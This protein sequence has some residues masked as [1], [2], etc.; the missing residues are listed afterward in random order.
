MQLWP[1]RPG[2]DAISVQFIFLVHTYLFL[3]LSRVGGGSVDAN[4][5]PFH[6]V[7]KELI[8]SRKYYK[9]KSAG[10]RLSSRPSRWTSEL[11]TWPDDDHRDDASEAHGHG[12][13]ET[14]ATLATDEPWSTVARVRSA[15]EVGHISACEAPLRCV[16]AYPGVRRRS[17]RLTAARGRCLRGWSGRCPAGPAAVQHH[18]PALHCARREPMPRRCC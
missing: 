14:R 3:P 6:S 18:H 7:D 8:P 13:A 17:H 4:R 16:V 11:D 12:A 10:L 9:G 5:G 2:Q 15:C 1:A